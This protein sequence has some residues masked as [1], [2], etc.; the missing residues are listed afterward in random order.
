MWT[1]LAL[2]NESG[3]D[4]IASHGQDQWTDRLRAVAHF[5]DCRAW[6]RGEAYAKLDHLLSRM[7]TDERDQVRDRAIYVL[8]TRGADGFRTLARLYDLSFG[9]YGEP[10][11]NAQGRWARGPTPDR[12]GA[13]STLGLF[14]R[15]DVD[16]YLYTY[17]A[18]QTGMSAPTSCLR[19]S[20]SPRPSAPATPTSWRPRRIA[21]R[22]PTSSIP[23]TRPNPACRIRTKASR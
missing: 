20:R 6:E 13:G 22:R 16:A 11:D 10:L 5:D 21:G 7:S 18:A 1:V 8:S 17:L 23:P 9:P 12:A 14:Q 4:A 19:T 15:N 3:Y 2:A